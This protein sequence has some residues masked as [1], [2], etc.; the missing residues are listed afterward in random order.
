MLK[1]ATYFCFSKLFSLT[2]TV[3]ISISVDVNQ[4]DG[5][6]PG[7]ISPHLHVFTELIITVWCLQLVPHTFQVMRSKGCHQIE[8]NT[9]R[10]AVLDVSV[11]AE[12]SHIS[13]APQNRRALEDWHPLDG[14]CYCNPLILMTLSRVK[15]QDNNKKSSVSNKVKG[16]LHQLYT[17]VCLSLH[18]CMRKSSI[19]RICASRGSCF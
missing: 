3:R 15:L 8:H 12:V 4:S 5:S 6:D 10:Y 2:C 7:V 1:T 17:L 11:P 16:Q 9:C 18:T 14:A 19:K 13:K